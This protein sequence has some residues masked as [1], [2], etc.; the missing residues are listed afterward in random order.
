MTEGRQVVFAARRRM[1]KPRRMNTFLNLTALLSLSALAAAAPAATPAK[2]RVL[3]AGPAHCQV[4]DGPVQPCTVRRN[5]PGSFDVETKGE[6]PLLAYVE[7]DGVYV[8]EVYGPEKTQ[9]PLYGTYAVDPKDS[10]CWQ[11]DDS[12]VAIRE[13]CVH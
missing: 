9:I 3:K 8:F 4:N 5:K 13:F 2:A 6:M 10:A 12:D 1:L 7:S 11:A